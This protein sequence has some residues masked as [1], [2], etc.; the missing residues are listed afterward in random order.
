MRKLTCVLGLLAATTAPSCSSD[1][2]PRPGTP[3][4]DA[5]PVSGRV[6]IANLKGPVDVVRDK[7][8]VAHIYATTLE[9][10][11]RVQGYQVA[12]DRTAQLELIRRSAT[13]RLAEVLGDLS[14]DTIDDDIAVRTLGLGRVGKEMYEAL[15]ADLK[16]WVDAYADGITQFNARVLSGDE[17]LP[18]TMIG[19]PKTMFAPFT[20]ADVLAVARLQASNLSYDVD[21]EIG[22]TE[23]LEKARATFRAGAADPDHARRAGFLLD[24]WRFAPNDPT[25]TMKGLPN[26]VS[27]TM[28]LSRQPAPQ[29]RVIAPTPHVPAA[30]LA[31]TRTWRDAMKRV[32]GLVGEHPEIGSN[33]WI[34]GPS[35]SAT[36]HAMLANDPHLGLSAAPIFWLVHVKVAHP[37][38][39]AEQVEF[40]GTAFPGIPGVI[41]GFNE[42]L[43]WG[44]TTVDY[45]V[46][47][48]FKETLT[49]D[50]GGVVFNGQPVPFKKVRETI[51]IAGKPPLEYDVLVVPHHGPVLPNVVDHR[52]VPL[53]PAKG[54][55]STQWTGHLAT[56]DFKF[57]LGLLRGKTVEDAR[58]AL[59]DFATGGQNWVFADADGNIFYSSQVI[60]PNRDR[61]AF[62]WDA[63]TFQGTLPCFV[64]PGDGTAEWRG[65]LDEA[66][67]PHVKNPKEGFAASANGDPAGYTL[68]NDPSND[69]LPNGQP[70]F[71]QCSHSMGYRIG[72]IDKL[73][74][75][76]A[77]P[78]TL[79]DMSAIQN[80]ARS[81]VGSV[82]AP[83]ILE[84]IAHAE[85]EQRAPGSR[86]GLTALVTSPRWAAAKIDDV[87]DTLLRWGRDADYDAA[88]GMNPDDN[89]PSADAK[90][91]LASKA[92]LMFN[93]WLVRMIAATL[94]DELAVIGGRRGDVLR[95]FI[96]LM[97][98]PPSELATFSAQTGDSILFDDLKTPGVLETK[99][100]RIVASLLD[101]L[102]F[103]GKKLGDD[104]AA[105]RWGK[106]HTLRFKS[107]VS[108]WQSMS[109]PPGGDPVFP[110][111]FPR[112]GDLQAVDVA[113][114]GFYRESLD[115]VDFS[116]GSGPTQRFVV[117]MT[118][119]G[120][121]AHN[122]L[123]GGNVWDPASPHMKD[124]AELWR[125]NK[126]HPIAF[127]K[128][129]VIKEAEERV[130]YETK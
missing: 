19:L 33:N 21:E 99:D 26:D 60:V 113:N 89:R 69:T 74:R 116:Y 62:A 114:Y 52:I 9:D 126:T 95:G 63:K 34:V 27:R 78:L 75:D 41:L 71:W 65:T 44:S 115:A 98:T 128:D 90:E 88:S 120:P 76:H 64:L 123:P 16:S 58:A 55:I 46:S 119:R 110:N 24:T 111:G 51:A 105:W 82:L 4:G 104:R 6:S 107:L 40:A 100:E 1:P 92:T 3:F 94:S 13:G 10:A 14:P 83:K 86:P 23:Y 127:A 12:R 59:R 25:L 37:S 81:Y 8:G 54:A 85:E 31:S 79:D 39:P 77:G 118:P 28:G 129:D 48:A 2:A 38:D 117:E 18:S 84:A 15:P 108:L 22:D 112:H 49:P 45:D 17:T 20:G 67:I 122:V 43:A 66:Y 72:R 97:T 70:A 53:D 61:R 56:N 87:K 102:D 103:L 73:L 30:L 96:H 101:A 130:V 5:V 11:F 7:Y 125:R 57:V 93:T 121:I 68:D 29:A 109:V 36:G 80:D 91:A 42:R 50:G 32:R 106:L 47:D 35:R 124:G